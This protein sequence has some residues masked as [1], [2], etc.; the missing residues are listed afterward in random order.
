[1]KFCIDFLLLFYR[2]KIFTT[3]DEVFAIEKTHKNIFFVKDDTALSNPSRYNFTKLKIEMFQ[4][5]HSLKNQY[6]L[7]LI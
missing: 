4:I 1:M 6:P 7:S 2:N 5:N 3:D